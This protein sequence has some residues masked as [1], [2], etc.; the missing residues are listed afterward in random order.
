VIIIEG[1]DNSGKTTLV[2][3]LLA[4]DPTLRLLHRERF[5]PD[6]GEGIG[7]SYLRALLPPDGDRVQH[8]NSVADRL[9][10]SEC[11]YG[12]LYR[13]GCRM[14]DGQHLAIRNVLRGY[15][16]IVVLC[17]PTDEVI[18]RSW[19]EREQLYPD[20]LR[21]ARAYRKRWSEIFPG[22]AAVRY[23]F[24]DK[25]AAG[26]RANLLSVHRQW[27]SELRDQLSWWSAI[28]FGAG[29]LRN[30]RLVLIG[31]GLSPIATTTVPFAHGPAGDF[32][33]WAIAA[34]EKKI[35]SIQPRLYVTNADKGTDRN[36]AL[37]REELR[38]LR[39]ARGASVIALGREAERLLEHVASVLPS[40]VWRA[41]LPHPQY[42]RRFN[43]NRRGEYVAQ[44]IKI[45]Q[46]KRSL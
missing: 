36:A 30:P 25:H 17:D 16:A 39:L 40:G 45:L 38:Q 41:A 1:P 15:G 8:A 4:A 34:A 23:N 26:I 7:D 33:A 43:W 22:F 6:A 14:R 2:S 21:V 44:L 37:L 24:N 11:V 27:L 13:G 29:C 32:L 28:P 19:S 3:E 12:E 5:K 20:P 42:W 31:E 18:Q 10:A 9:F 35:G 46:R